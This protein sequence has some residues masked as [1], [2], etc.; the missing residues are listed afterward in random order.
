MQLAL[1]H[2]GARERDHVV[3]SDPPDFAVLDPQLSV[4]VV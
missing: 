1:R 2:C 3:T 4:I